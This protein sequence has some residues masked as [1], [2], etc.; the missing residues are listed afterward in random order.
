[1]I[2]RNVEANLIPAI[3]AEE[4]NKK[5]QGLCN[6][7]FVFSSD[8]AVDSWTEWAVRN[9]EESGVQAVALE[10]FSAW[11][12]FK[13]AY[14]AGSLSGK[15]CIPS[16][17][18][19]LFI[20]SLIHQNLENHF[21]KKI[22]PSDDAQAAYAFTDWLSKILPS[23]NLWNKKY[24][25][26]LNKNN[27]SPESDPDIENHDYYQIYTRY[28]SFLEANHFFE[29][30]WLT[31]E[32]VEKE[33]HIIIFYPELLEDF[34]DYEDVL[35]KAENV[36]LIKLPQ[37]QS[38]KKIYAYKYS[39]SRKELRHT[40]LRLRQL[41]EQGVKW[42]EMALS[43][44]DIEVYRPYIRRECQL[45]CIPLNI[46][47]GEP[48]TKNCAGLI[49]NQLN[50]CVTSNFSYSSLR[51]LLQNEYLPWKEDVRNLKEVLIR[52]G[53][54]LRT[55]CSYEKD[56]SSTESVDTWIQALSSVSKDE[57]ELTFYKTLKNEIKL[58]C[59]AES[60]ETIRT[61]W[62]IFR[63]KFLDT[64]NFTGDANK[65]LGRCISELEDMIDIERR[66]LKPLNLLSKSPFA[67]FLNEINSKTYRP[68]EALTGLSVFPY[69][70][71]AP[72]FFKYQFVIDASQ[73]KLDIPFKK[74]SFLNTEKRKLLLGA[75]VDENAN[76]SSTFV[77]LYAK[78]C[79]PL[80]EKVHF[81]YA[82][83]TFDG[84]AIAHNSLTIVEESEQEKENQRALEESDFIKKEKSLLYS[85]D[86]DSSQ[87][88]QLTDLQKTSFLDWIERTKKINQIEKEELTPLLEEKIKKALVTKRKSE[89]KIV[90]TQSDLNKF[91]P[92][93]RKW[94]LKS[95]L[96]LKD[97]SLDT[98]LMQ[99][100]DMGNINHKILEFYMN[101]L[102]AKEELLP[103]TN[104]DGLFDKEDEIY[105]KILNYTKLAIHDKSMDFKDSPIVLT[106]LDSQ[107]SLIADG[108]MNFLYTFCLAPSKPED[109]KCNSRTSIKGFGGY[110]VLGDELNFSSKVM[111]DEKDAEELSLYGK[112]DCLLASEEGEYVIIDYK[113]TLSAIPSEGALS[114]DENG[115][116]GDFQMPMYVSLIK[117]EK[118]PQD[119]TIKVEAA[120][121][122]AIK[123]ANR[124][125]AID[126][127]RGLASSAP[128]G[129]LNIKKYDVFCA[130]T[131]L[132]FNK[133]MADFSERIKNG[134]FEPINPKEKKDHFVHV[135]PYK[136]CASC[137]YKSICRTTFTVGEKNLLTGV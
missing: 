93:P 119:S 122:Y 131:L 56:S 35:S 42:T 71:S 128:E 63:E 84:F 27:L 50:D 43:V 9:P 8:V 86:F 103:V 94:L 112:I 29:P 121:F 109:G 28:N 98:S 133:Y 87:K 83:E 110:K 75:D 91:Y 69:R 34:S 51:A 30:S 137:D 7:L 31:P 127:Y 104:E 62:L 2:I 74:L 102:A 132:L 23:L 41:H 72:A 97:D 20:R 118:I 10:D 114:Q 16:L 64:E 47:A 4:L 37:N 59:Q 67:F 89:S 101:E 57:R 1:M 95:I 26:F 107:L 39:D 11:D 38:E 76:A 130:N 54:R 79:F 5:S 55:I 3:L 15:I 58:I 73:K 19:K 99:T 106:T 108:I 61:A 117:N 66:Y 13:S 125:A 22:V 70:L 24:L 105:N 68:Q 113:N 36:T 60:F 136:V 90:I 135:E 85:K 96:N 77:H 92:C 18:R 88:L 53:N 116:L 14:L 33:R 129:S 48:L 49:F 111:V 12:K 17:L 46:R 120:Y 100:F 126:E 32:F 52:E 25:E 124:R 80:G 44:P 78:E 81:S 45:Y 40:L 6:P 134:R 115:L 82:E 65:I 21:I 123:D